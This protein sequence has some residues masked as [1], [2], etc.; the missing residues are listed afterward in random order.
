MKELKAQLS[1]KSFSGVY[2]FAGEEKFLIE[3][4]LNRF[5]DSIFEG[6]DK[7][8]NLDRFNKES[9]DTERIITSLETLPFFADKR[10]VVLYEMGLFDKKKSFA[11]ELPEVFE[12]VTDTSICFIIE[13]KIDKRSKLYKYI[14]KNGMFCEFSYLKEKELIS[15]IARELKKHNK[16][17]SSRA[18]SH[19]LHNVGYDLNT[20]NIELAKLIDY[21][22]RN[23]V[24]SEEDI[25]DVCVKHLESR[26]FD[27]VDATGNKNRK[28]SLQLFYDMMTLR[29]PT[30]RILFMI[31]RQ[32]NLLFQVKLMAEKR[33]S[34]Q[35]IARELK[36]PP[37]VVEKLKRQSN[38][39][40]IESLK[41]ILKELVELEHHFK[42]GKI[43]LETGI[44]LMIIKMSQTK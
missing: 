32:I 19:F 14:N 35:D 17:I 38:N 22:S 40:T 18:V 9:K 4:Y 25:D 43:N 12:N 37:F 44:E 5:L 34:K 7:T 20:I 8:M 6:Q 36:L 2:L 11:A 16:K 29:E 27:L 42:S 15:Y 26:I 39:Y 21:C 33:R 13:E 31:S 1:N 23:E 30:T 41:E 3:L 24:V 28:L 10:V